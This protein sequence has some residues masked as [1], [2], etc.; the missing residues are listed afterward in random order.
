[1]KFHEANKLINTLPDE[2]KKAVQRSFNG[3]LSIATQEFFIDV[4]KLDDTLGQMD[5]EYNPD[6]C[7]YKGK[8]VSMSDYIKEK[9]GD[10]AFSIIKSLL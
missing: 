7:T 1:M 9:Y 2:L 4:V 8:N 6:E 5:D 10:D 3:Q